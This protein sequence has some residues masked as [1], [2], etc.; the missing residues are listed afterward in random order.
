MQVLQSS[1][2]AGPRAGVVPLHRGGT[3]QSKLMP[4]DL[5]CWFPGL[6]F[7][8]DPTVHTDA[9]SC[10]RIVGALFGLLGHA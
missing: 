5:S 6:G 4:T 10:S 8:P 1:R 2:A 9:I 7:N 3:E